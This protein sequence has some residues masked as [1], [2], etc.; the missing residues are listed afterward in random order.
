MSTYY[1]DY[2]D[3]EIDNEG[4]I[5]DEIQLCSECVDQYSG[6]ND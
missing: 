6:S 1:C 2:C 3:E 4:L 5:S